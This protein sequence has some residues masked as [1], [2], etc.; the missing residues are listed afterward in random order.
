MK[1]SLVW[2]WWVGH[3][4]KVWVLF[5]WWYDFDLGFSIGGG[6][7]ILGVV[8]WWYDFFWCFGVKGLMEMNGV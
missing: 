7:W 5:D 4:G 3:G 1:A 6:G 2:G 8:V